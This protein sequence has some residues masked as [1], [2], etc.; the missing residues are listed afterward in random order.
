MADK[1]AKMDSSIKTEQLC[2]RLHK[3]AVIIRIKPRQ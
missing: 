1:T 3:Q 2:I